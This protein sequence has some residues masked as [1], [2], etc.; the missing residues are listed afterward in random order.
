MSNELPRSK[1]RGIRSKKIEK[2]DNS[3]RLILTSRNYFCTLS[4]FFVVNFR[5]INIVAKPINKIAKTEPV[6]I[7]AVLGAPGFGELVGFG[8]TGVAVGVAE[9]G[10]GVGVAKTSGDFGQP[11]TNC[12]MEILLT[13]PAVRA[14]PFH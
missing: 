3:R 10:V 2:R 1:V 11:I 4:V 13:V 5:K 12:G 7:I 9:G 14:K 8:E 6:A